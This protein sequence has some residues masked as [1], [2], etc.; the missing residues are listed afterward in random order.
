MQVVFGE[1]RTKM[2]VVFAEVYTKVQVVFAEILTKMHV[3]F[4]EILTKMHVNA[5]IGGQNAGLF[6]CL[7]S[8]LVF[9]RSNFKR[10]NFGQNLNP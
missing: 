2:H 5:K 8:Q 3:V 9:G 4:A 10:K 1:F 7:F 6:R